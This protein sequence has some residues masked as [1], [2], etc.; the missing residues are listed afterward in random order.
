MHIFSDVDFNMIEDAIKIIDFSV[1]AK[2]VK[3]D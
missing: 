2:K 3:L 1:S